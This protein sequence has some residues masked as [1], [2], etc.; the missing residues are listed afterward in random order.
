MQNTRFDLGPLALTSS[1]TTNIF[2]PGTTTGGIA[3]TSAPFDK[4]YVV[5]TH[6]WVV[7]KG[8]GA[9]TFRLY[10]GATGANAAGTEIAYDAN[11]PAGGRYDI[12]L[13][14]LRFGTTQFLVGGASAA[15]TLT[16]GGCGEIGIGA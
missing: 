6:L 10:R 16:I 12:P 11:V 4:L 13:S 14:G 5:L 7:N 3:C 9:A 1:Y 15:T 8:A 2:Q